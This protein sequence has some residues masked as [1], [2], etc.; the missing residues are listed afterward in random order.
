MTG[1][2]EEVGSGVGSEDVAVGIKETKEAVIF[3]VGLAGAVD[4]QLKDGFQYSD[5]FSLI[6]VLSKLPAA[7][8]GADK[9]AAELADLDDDERKE[10]L[11]AIK[12]LDLQ[13]DAVEEIAEHACVAFIDL[14][15]LVRLIRKAR[16]K[17][18]E[19]APEVAG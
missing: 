16:T 19:D 11:E 18:T 15:K 17:P 3:M 12:K 7:V 13:D 2:I 4:E 5:L 9:I 10:L 6:P 1:S 14:F 8:E